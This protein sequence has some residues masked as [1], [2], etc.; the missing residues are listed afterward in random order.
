MTDLLDKKNAEEQ[1]AAEATPLVEDEGIAV[2]QPL[3]GDEENA[4]EKDAEREPIIKVVNLTKKFGDL[5]VL[6]DITESIYEGEKV[7]IV[8]P[9][10]GGKS[11]FLRF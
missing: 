2:A 8:G 9:S 11:T 4:P 1:T 10:G 6:D 5:L 3:A 7:V